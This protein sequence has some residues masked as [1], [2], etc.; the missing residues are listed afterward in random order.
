MGTAVDP[1]PG[2]KKSS[3]CKDGSGESMKLESR[4]CE[5]EDVDD[6]ARGKGSAAFRRSGG[7]LGFLDHR[8]GEDA[9]DGGIHGR[10]AALQRAGMDFAGAGAVHETLQM[11]GDEDVSDEQSDGEAEEEGPSR[12]FPED[13]EQE[14]GRKDDR[15]PC[16]ERGEQWK[17]A[18]EKG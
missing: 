10:Q 9:K 14:R 5:H 7:N 12:R 2:D 3:H 17:N 6:M 4:R 8:S 11:G 13:Q 1:R 15:F 16:V 18:I